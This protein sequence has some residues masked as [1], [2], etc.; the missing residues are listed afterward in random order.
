MSLNESRDPQRHGSSCPCQ[1]GTG[2]SD[3]TLVDEKPTSSALAKPRPSVRGNSKRSVMS[4]NSVSSVEYLLGDSALAFPSTHPCNGRDRSTLVKIIRSLEDGESGQAL[5][6]SLERGWRHPSYSRH[7]SPSAFRRVGIMFSRERMSWTAGL[8]V[9]VTSSCGP[10]QDRLCSVLPYRIWRPV[11]NHRCCCSSNSTYL[12]LLSANAR[13]QKQESTTDPCGYD[14]CRGLLGPNAHTWSSRLQR[15]HGVP[16][17][18][19]CGLS[20]MRF[21]MTGI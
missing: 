6:S 13:S 7:S 9:G 12:W 8:P 11:T 21:L 20:E 16:P 4:G 17:A 14:L 3:R 19:C 18:H 2:A 10:G 5:A 15:K 1:L